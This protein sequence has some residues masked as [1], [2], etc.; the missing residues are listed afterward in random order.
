[1]TDDWQDV[2][3]QFREAEIL[4]ALEPQ[5]AREL[6]HDLAARMALPLGSVNVLLE[7]VQALVELNL[8]LVE[9][10]LRRQVVTEDEV[11]ACMKEASLDFDGGVAGHIFSGVLAYLQDGDTRLVR[12]A[13]ISRTLRQMRGPHRSPSTADADPVPDSRQP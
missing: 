5:A 9:L 4:R 1:M 3:A 2:A 12:T 7:S 13:K 10:L 6:A 11:I 8:S